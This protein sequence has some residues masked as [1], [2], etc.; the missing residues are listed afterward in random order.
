MI[1]VLSRRD[2]GQLN[3]KLPKKEYRIPAPQDDNILI[4]TNDEQIKYINFESQFF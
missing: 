2:H 1:K 3:I 4:V